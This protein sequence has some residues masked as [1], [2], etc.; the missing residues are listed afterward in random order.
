MRGAAPMNVG[1]TTPQFS[2]ILS[3]RPSIAVAKPHA[4]W[5]A[6]STLPKACASGSHSSCRSS[7]PSRPM[8]AITPPVYT[9]AS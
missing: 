3:T 2:T 7:S 6:I 8:S 9:Q 4:T 1:L 5:V